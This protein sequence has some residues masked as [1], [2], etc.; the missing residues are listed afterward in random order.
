[1]PYADRAAQQKYQREWV[2]RRRREWLEQNGPCVDCGSWEQLE[3]DHE[4]PTK[5][6]THRV[7]SWAKGP[8]DA[9][10]AKCSVRCKKCHKKRTAAFLSQLNK[11]PITHGI[12]SA[13]LQHGCR[14][15]VCKA[16]YS[17]WRRDKY[18]R[19]GK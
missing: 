3:V 5:K 11:R 6:L 4:D 14:C 7:W 18:Q 12:V 10:L 15:D 13:Y 1:M 8:R 9:E 17:R 19:I 16:F 2:A